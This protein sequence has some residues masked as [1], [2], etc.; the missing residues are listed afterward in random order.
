MV[1][2]RGD[3]GDLRSVSTIFV[4]PVVFSA[5]HAA[6]LPPACGRVFV[7]VGAHPDRD[8]SGN[9]VV[10]EDTD[11]R[12]PRQTSTPCV[13][14]PGRC[15]QTDSNMRSSLRTQGLFADTKLT[16]YT[17]VATLPFRPA[18]SKS[19]LILLMD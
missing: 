15:T 11:A 5:R 3:L 12:T 18:V 14:T 8:V 2:P 4:H 17:R 13:H 19:L 7:V 6:Q 16:S 10:L 1:C 9:E